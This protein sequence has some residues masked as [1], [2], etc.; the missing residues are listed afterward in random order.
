MADA[1]EPQTTAT[2][3]QVVVWKAANHFEERGLTARDLK[4]LG[5]D[6]VEADKVGAVYWNAAN[7]W[8][9]PLKDV[10][11]SADQVTTLARL[12]SRFRLDEAR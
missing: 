6:E 11:L 3:Q 8:T 7:N 5:A 4:G 12:D 1:K 2:P 9:V 10:P